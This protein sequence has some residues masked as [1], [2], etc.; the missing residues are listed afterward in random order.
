MTLY[1]RILKLTVIVKLYSFGFGK[2][3]ILIKLYC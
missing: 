3:E 2:Y 1:V